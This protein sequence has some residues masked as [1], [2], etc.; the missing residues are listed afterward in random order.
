M[1]VFRDTINIPSQITGGEKP[2][3]AV[4]GDLEKPE[5]LD[6][7]G[8]DAVVAS[9]PLPPTDICTLTYTQEVARTLRSKLKEANVQ[10]L[11]FLSRAGAQ[12]DEGVVSGFHAHCD[13]TRST[14]RV[15]VD[16]RV[17]SRRT[18][19]PRRSLAMPLCKSCLFAPSF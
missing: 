12:S 7:T 1:G 10:R 5:T 18:M 6:F 9:I 11:V 17:R 19:Q 15:V 2:F 16:L 4:P 8:S 3:T 13:P 14:N